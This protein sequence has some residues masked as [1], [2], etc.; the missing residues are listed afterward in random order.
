MEQVAEFIFKRGKGSTLY[1]RR[2]IPANLRGAYPKKT[3]ITRSL[4]TSSMPEA[5]AR[6]RLELAQIDAQ[7]LDAREKLTLSRASMAAKRVKKLSDHQI[8]GVAKFWA[9]QVLLA[10]EQ[11]RSAG[12]DDDEFDELGEKLITQRKDFGRMLAQGKT[13]PILPALRGFLYLCGLDF[14]PD[15]EQAKRASYIFL[16]TVV[17]TVEYQLARQSGNVIETDAV[18]EDVMHPLQ[19]I[20]P[21]R[22]PRRPDQPG[23]DEVFK[24]WV[25][26]VSDRPKSTTIAAQTPWR[27]LQRYMA[28]RGKVQS[29]SEVQPLDMTAFAEDMRARNLAVATINERIT[30]IRSIYKIAVGKHVLVS[31]PAA[32]TL[33]F[34]ESS[35]EKRRKR[36]LSFDTSDVQLIFQSPVFTQHRRSKGQSG[37]AVYWIPLIMFYSG[38]RPEEAAG[39]AISDLRRDDVLGWYFAIVD[40]PSSEDEEMFGDGVPESHRR[41]LKNGN[42][43]RFVPIAQQL[44]DLGLLRYV[45][46]LKGQGKAVLFPDLIKDWHGKLS[47]SFSKFFSRYKRVVGIEDPRKVLYSFR[48]TMKDLMESAKIPSKYLQRILGHTSGDGAVTD[49]YGSD[50]P[51]HVIVEMFRKIKFPEIEAQPWER[52]QGFISLKFGGGS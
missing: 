12:L 7:F 29:P 2:R 8:Q 21:E 39:L 47:G 18:T 48:H 10:D 50:V 11:Q 26:Y 1:V 34:K 14:D 41:T 27:D 5:K 3:H 19:D 23:W 25:E 32:N 17:Q 36:R 49:G 40:R 6:A 22:A 37:E 30:K 24:V 31:N 51:F 13:E 16:Q 38:M 42:S 46:E 9:R 44:I 43:V 52:G 28:A 45:E 4:G 15:E 20:A 33:G 35:V